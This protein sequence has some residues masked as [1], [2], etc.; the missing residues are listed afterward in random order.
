MKVQLKGLEKQLGY[1]LQ[2]CNAFFSFGLPS[3]NSKL[4]VKYA[5]EMQSSN[6]KI[7]TRY[8][9]FTLLSKFITLMSHLN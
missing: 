4:P 6:L 8:D 2:V 5:S 7:K 3:S 9:D 1:S